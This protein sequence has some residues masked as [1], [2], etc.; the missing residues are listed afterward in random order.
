MPFGLSAVHAIVAVVIV[1]I[2]F[3]PRWLPRLGRSARRSL[4]EF[5]TAVPA[6]RD[7]FVSE[8]SAPAKTNAGQAVGRS[9]GALAGRSVRGTLDAAAA[10]RAGFENE[11]RGVGASTP[12]APQN[13]I[14]T[15]TDRPP[16]SPS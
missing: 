9:I 3:G 10:A 12:S 7:A 1:L 6:T 8:T 14:S 11:F 13:P 16:Q 5:R 15:D 2:A 4:D